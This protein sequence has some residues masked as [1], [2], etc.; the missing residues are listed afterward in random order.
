MDIRFHGSRLKIERANEHILDL[1]G[2]LL[3]FIRSDFYTVRV[4]R[5]ARKGTS[6][7]CIDFDPSPFP[8]ED[9]ALVIG[10]ALHN[11]RSALDL[12]YYEV[13]RE[14]GASKWTRF[15]VRDT[16]DELI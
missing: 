15:P 6:H 1:N 13:V 5:D 2:V 12:L 10:D 8:S 9:A 11:L 16:R 7:L 14:C 4:D 3:R